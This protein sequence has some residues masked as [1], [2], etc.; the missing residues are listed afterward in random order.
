MEGIEL[1][2]NHGA[3]IDMQDDTGKTGLHIVGLTGFLPLASLLLKR[4]ASMTIKDVC[5]RTAVEVAKIHSNFEVYD[6]LAYIVNK[7]RRET[8][9]SIY[10]WDQNQTEGNQGICCIL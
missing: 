7:N 4:G 1:L 10:S 9:S 2:L 6:M 5:G 3:D 8:S